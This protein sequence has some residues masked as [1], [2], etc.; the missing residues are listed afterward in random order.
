MASSTGYARP[1]PSDALARRPGS[2]RRGT[3]ARSGR[4]SRIRPAV[5]VCEAKGILNDHIVLGILLYR[6]I[7]A[8]AGSASL[9]A[10]IA[11]SSRPGP[12]IVQRQVCGTHSCGAGALRD[13]CGGP[14]GAPD[15]RP[16]TVARPPRL[17]VGP[18]P[19]CFACLP[20]A[21]R[22][23]VPGRVW[24]SLRRAL[25]V[26]RRRPL[27]AA[28]VRSG[29]TSAVSPSHGWLPNVPHHRSPSR[30]A[31]RRPQGLS[32]RAPSPQFAVLHSGHCRGTETATRR[33]CLL[34]G[35]AYNSLLVGG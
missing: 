30:F 17:P 3:A 8:V 31:S 16:L 23:A 28:S 34:Q 9:L 6:L 13:L 11:R 7:T 4:L 2:A 14:A 22:R 35:S 1:F 24:P 29:V 27:H 10:T 5:A 20:R 12:E 21:A 32:H 25:Q 15:F 19:L 26:C 18:R 33:G